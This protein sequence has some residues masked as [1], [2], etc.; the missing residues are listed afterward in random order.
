[1]LRTAVFSEP[2][3][4][5]RLSGDGLLHMSPLSKG[6]WCVYR[7]TGQDLF[8]GGTK[9][10]QQLFLRRFPSSVT[11]KCEEERCDGAF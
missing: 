9:A 10:L 3:L 6:W 2:A 1:M 7:H 5:L 8:S 11:G 4:Y